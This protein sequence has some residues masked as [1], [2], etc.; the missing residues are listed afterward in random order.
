MIV[1]L[2]YVQTDRMSDYGF[3]RQKVMVVGTGIS[4][5]GP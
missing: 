4:G 5:T 1:S 3:K 2:Y